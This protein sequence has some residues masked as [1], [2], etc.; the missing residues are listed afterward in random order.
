MRPV[1]LLYSLTSSELA[2]SGNVGVRFQQHI[3]AVFLIF[4][5]GYDFVDF[6]SAI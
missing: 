6:E 4:G 5:V 3:R 1:N 2:T